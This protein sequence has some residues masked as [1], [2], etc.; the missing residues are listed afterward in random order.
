MDAFVSSLP[1][2]DIYEDP[3]S[4]P[5]KSSSKKS[6]APDLL[7]AMSLFPMLR[8]IV[9]ALFLTLVASPFTAPFETCD[10]TA[11]FGS[12]TAVAPTQVQV[13]WTLE[14]DCHAVA[15]RAATS[16]RLRQALPVNPDTALA[17]SLALPYDP[18]SVRSSDRPDQRRS[19]HARSPL[20]I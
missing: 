5:G 18:A 12:P 16:R 19:P 3:V 10:L 11:L 13:A 9:A 7:P 1:P 2:S 17:P 14:E 8:R 15:P 20:R 6:L 4:P